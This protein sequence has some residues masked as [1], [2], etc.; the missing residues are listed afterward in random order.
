MPI[1]IVII[2]KDI[3]YYKRYTNDKVLDI[4]GKLYYY[5]IE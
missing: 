2:I 4:T 5:K 3:Q 1:L